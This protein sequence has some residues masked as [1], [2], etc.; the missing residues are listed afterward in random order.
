MP[1]R[2]AASSD[3]APRSQSKPSASTSVSHSTNVGHEVVQQR[4][5]R[6]EPIGF[7]TRSN[8]SM[9]ALTGLVVVA[10]HTSSAPNIREPV[11]VTVWSVCGRFGKSPEDHLDEAALFELLALAKKQLRSHVGVYT[12]V[13]RWSNLPV[14]EGCAADDEPGHDAGRSQGES[15]RHRVG[16]SAC[17]AHAPSGNSTVTMG[18]DRRAAATRTT[19]RTGSGAEE[20]QE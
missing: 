4:I 16:D 2:T 10:Q 17:G 9:I 5:D 7:R 14:H 18:R 12:N 8:V 11:L 6:R 19:D 20:G 13:P 15:A 1:W 3:P